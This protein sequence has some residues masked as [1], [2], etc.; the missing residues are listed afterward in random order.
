ME[1][2]IAL[3]NN[4]ALALWYKWVSWYIFGSSLFLSV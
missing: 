3:V 1:D 2:F 4:L